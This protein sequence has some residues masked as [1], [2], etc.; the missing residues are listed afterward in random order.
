[1]SKHL[2]IFFLEMNFLEKEAEMNQN[3]Q[4]QIYLFIGN[5]GTDTKRI[6][7]Q[8]DEHYEYT[9]SCEDIYYNSFL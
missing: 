6:Y 3:F 7:E 2:E 1:M 8:I 5:K 4:Q 9:V